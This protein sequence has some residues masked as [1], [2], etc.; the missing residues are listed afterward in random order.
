MSDRLTEGNLIQPLTVTDAEV[1]AFLR[2]NACALCRGSLQARAVPGRKWE[3]ICP[4][5]GPVLATACVSKSKLERIESD[6]R[7]AKQ[8]LRVAKPAKRRSVDEILSDLGF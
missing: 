6:L 4:S 2:D 3:I 7:A 1:G 5:C 8:E